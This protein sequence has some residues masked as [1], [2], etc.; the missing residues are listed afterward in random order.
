[1]KKHMEIATPEVYRAL[2]HPRASIMLRV[3]HIFAAEIDR[4][5]LHNIG[6]NSNSRPPFRGN[7][8]RRSW[9]RSTTL[10]SLHADVPTRKTT[11][12]SETMSETVSETE[13]Q[14]AT[15]Y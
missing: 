12:V 7:A 2:P 10:C 13:G 11:P 15:M 9:E 6:W 1:M 4:A 14:K 8:L 5:A 3:L